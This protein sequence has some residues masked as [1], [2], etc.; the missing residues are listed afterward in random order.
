MFAELHGTERKMV[1]AKVYTYHK[2]DEPL[3]TGISLQG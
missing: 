3:P 2:N 1:L